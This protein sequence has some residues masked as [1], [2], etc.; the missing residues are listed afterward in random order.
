MANQRSAGTSGAFERAM[1]QLVLQG[2]PT[3][4][5]RTSEAALL[6]DGPALGLEGGAVYPEQV[7][8]LHA[9][10]ARDRPDEQRV[11]KSRGRPSSRSLVAS[12]PASSGKA[13]SSSSITTPSS[14][15]MAGSISS[16]RSTTGW[17]GTE[18]LA[19][20]DPEQQRVS[21]LAGGTGDGDV[22]GPW[23]SERSAAR[24]AG[25]SVTARTLVRSVSGPAR[26]RS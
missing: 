9:G 10:L 13:Q 25:V 3:T 17:L 21:D 20:G 24:A 2:L 23:G 1:R 5:T 8:A 15:F 26:V 22:D 11:R 12:M 7:L 19:R 4:S 18:H 16:R 6:G 14:A